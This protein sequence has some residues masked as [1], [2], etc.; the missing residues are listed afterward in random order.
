MG[1]GQLLVL[2]RDISSELYLIDLK[3]YTFIDR[4]LSYSFNTHS[5][6]TEEKW[7]IGLPATLR[8]SNL[9]GH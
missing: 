3:V 1:E 2:F 8:S 9:G 7:L 6:A 4:V 5:Q